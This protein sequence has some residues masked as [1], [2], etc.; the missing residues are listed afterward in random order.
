MSTQQEQRLQVHEL[1][2]VGGQRGALSAPWSAPLAQPKP[3]GRGTE[4]AA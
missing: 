1:E 4:G 3:T 2:R